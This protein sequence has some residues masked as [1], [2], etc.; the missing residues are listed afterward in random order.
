MHIDHS[1]YT[2][3]LAD[4]SVS[5]LEKMKSL[6]AGENF[7][8]L[9]T[10]EAD[11]VF[12]L[13]KLRVPDLIIIRLALEEGKGVMVVRHLKQS[14]LTKHIPILY[15]TIPNRYE[16]FRKVVDYEGVEFIS[17][18]LSKKELILRINNQLLLLESQ[19]IIERQNERLQNVARSK[20]KL[21]SVIAHDLR[22][23]IG[24]LKM[25]LEAIDH[26]KEKI[27]D[28]NIR[29]LIKM[30]QETTDEA[31]LL[32]ENL[33]VW[34]NSRN[35]VLQP[36]RQEFSLSEAVKEVIAL[37]ANI[38]EAKEINICNHIVGS[39]TGYADVNMVKTVLR[40]LLSN[41]IKFSYTGGKIE[42]DCKE[43]NNFLTIS[44]KDYGQGISEEHQRSLLDEGLHFISYGTQKEKGS[45]L[46]LQ[47]CKDFV[48]LNHG[49]LWF[50]SKEGE[51]TT[52]YF[53][54]P[55]KSE[56]IK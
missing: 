21:Y 8:L 2:I 22:A 53:S 55:C 13:A 26:Q 25:I 47:L 34:S 4:D 48:K 10:L 32:L 18:P 41:A 40:N 28:M 39:N 6:L 56:F 46:G 51:G 35:G 16:D 20:D 49:K 45:G 7:K 12:L 31:Y 11:E 42:V 24:T 9:P 33:L 54:V 5:N 3:L 43:E 30:L 17:R 29:H 37:Q 38:A 44:V 19:R 15:M 14:V 23:P 1:E 52:F 36:Y 27:S 50:E